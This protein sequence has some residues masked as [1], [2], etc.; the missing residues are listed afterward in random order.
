[1]MN[2]SGFCFRI[3]PAVLIYEGST[4][5]VVFHALLLLAYDRKHVSSAA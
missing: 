5:I 3:G 2:A 4:L 1:M